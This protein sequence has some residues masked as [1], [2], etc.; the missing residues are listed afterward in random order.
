MGSPKYGIW[1]KVKVSAAMAGGG[2][3]LFQ[4]SSGMAGGHQH[5]QKNL[6]DGGLCG[7]SQKV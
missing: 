3:S 7:W 2:K 6:S 1:S 5:F 4:V